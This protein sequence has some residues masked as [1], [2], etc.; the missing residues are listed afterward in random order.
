MESPAKHRHKRS[1]CSHRWG[2][3]DS[4]H[5]S[6]GVGVCILSCLFS[7]GSDG[8]DNML[9]SRCSACTPMPNS[10]ASAKQNKKG[11]HGFSPGGAQLRAK[12]CVKRTMGFLHWLSEMAPDSRVKPR[13]VGHSLPVACHAWSSKRT[14]RTHARSDRHLSYHVR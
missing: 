11:R 14:V 5:Q 2:F 6:R 9:A 4:V 8:S 7:D 3:S 1:A 12:R 10:H 13:S